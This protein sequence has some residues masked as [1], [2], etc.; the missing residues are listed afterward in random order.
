MITKPKPK[1]L[2]C[3]ECRTI[4]VHRSPGLNSAGRP[5]WECQECGTK[6]AGFFSAAPT[7]ETIADGG[8]SEGGDGA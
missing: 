7:V 5:V 1:R 4:T 3:E 8:P 2:R 6:L